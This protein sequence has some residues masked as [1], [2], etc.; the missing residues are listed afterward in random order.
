MS[1][2][3]TPEPP[4]GLEHERVLEVVP[5][6]G[7]VGAGPDHRG[8]PGDVVATDGDVLLVDPGGAPDGGEDPL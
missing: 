6:G 4:L 8:A 5:A 3:V 1:L 7:H 2:L